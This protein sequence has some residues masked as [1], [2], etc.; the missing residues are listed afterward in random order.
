VTISKEI[1]RLEHSAIKLTI[2]VSKE[3]VNTEYAQIINDYRKTLQIPGFRKGKVPK[4]VLERKFGDSL[5]VEALGKILDRS[6][7]QVFED[8]DF[9]VTNRPLPY[10]TPEVQDEP[11]LDL[12][13]DLVFA[14]VYDVL[15]TVSLGTWQGLSVEVPE[16][17]ITDEDISQE[18]EV[19]RERNAI[20]F[21]KD[22]AAGAVPGDVVTIQY[23]ELSPSGDPIVGTERQDF[24]FT[25]G[26]GQNIYHLDDAMIGMTRGETRDIEKTYP[27]DFYDIDLAGKT[28]KIRVTLSG[29]KE[30][31]LPELN[32]DLAQDVDEKYATLEDLKASI[33]AQLN[34]DL[35][36]RLYVR[37]VNALLEKIMETSP[38]DIP[39]S[40][41]RFQLEARWRNVVR[42]MHI[43]QEEVPNLLERRDGSFGTL[44][45]VWRPEVIKALHSRLIVETIM[46]DRNLEVSDEV[47]EQEYA[48]I[49]ARANLPVEE[50]RSYHEAQEERKNMLVDTINDRQVHDVLLAENTI[51]LGNPMSY[52]ALVE[53]KGS[54]DL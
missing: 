17:K 32:D 52:H 1:T 9:P 13:A 11:K 49:A 50:I 18:L 53:S 39:E 48:R 3:D 43:P 35:E 20:V 19:I 28:K 27:A 23:S 10:S 25:L 26:S 46:K 12:G 14:V 29:L 24:V 40:M 22:D 6:I 8:P 51:T 37:K 16:V 5:K 47:I 31:D 41:I 42:N 33:R 38:V 44:A 30:K 2:T 4:E 15:P 54:K 45:E 36:Q 34:E 7:A 21:D